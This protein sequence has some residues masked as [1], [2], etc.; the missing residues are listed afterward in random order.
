MACIVHKGDILNLGKLMAEDN[1]T[2]DLATLVSQQ[3][4]APKPK[5]R[6][7]T[8]IW[9]VVMFLGIIASKFGYEVDKSALVEIVGFIFSLISLIGVGFGRAKSM[10][11]ITKKGS[12]KM[13]AKVQEAV[14]EAQVKI[15][16]S[17]DIGTTTHVV[18][19]FSP[20]LPPA[21]DRDR[22]G[23]WAGD[24]GPFID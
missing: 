1:R 7:S 11:P 22:G 21:S 13:R 5:W 18:Q 2:L 10:Q 20:Q 17:N 15:G 12:E 23:F 14:R 19:R 8:V 16:T 9:L 4:A 24:N 6:S 3:L